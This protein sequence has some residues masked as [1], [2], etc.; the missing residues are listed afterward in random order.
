MYVSAWLE[1]AWGHY[2]GLGESDYFP[3]QH[4]VLVTK[5]WREVGHTDWVCAILDQFAYYGF[6]PVY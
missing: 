2:E 6:G 5:I 1:N 4:I 3:I